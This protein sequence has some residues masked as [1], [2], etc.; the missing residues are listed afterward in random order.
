MGFVVVRRR[1]G[2]RWTTVR[3]SSRT[4]E[5]V[6][7][8]SPGVK[9]RGTV[10]FVVFA[11]LVLVAAV[12]TVTIKEG[13]VVALLLEASKKIPEGSGVV[14]IIERSHNGC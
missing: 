14:H 7:A 12:L 6:I 4:A 5:E 2:S 8:P 10:A 3:Q 1:R 11:L 13:M 9:G